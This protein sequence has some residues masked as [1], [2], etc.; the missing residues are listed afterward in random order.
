M[1]AK[2]TRDVDGARKPKEGPVHLLD[3]MEF[4]RKMTDYGL[5][6]SR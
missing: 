5:P 4:G 2:Y 1:V 6:H 3:A